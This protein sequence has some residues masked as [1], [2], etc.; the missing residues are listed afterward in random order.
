MDIKNYLFNFSVIT[1]IAITV[2]LR[3]AQLATIN[4]NPKGHF[5]K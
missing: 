2:I 3:A 1:I 4:V 5:D